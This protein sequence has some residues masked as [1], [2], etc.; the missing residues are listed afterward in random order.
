M[1]GPVLRA[2][3]LRKA[4]GGRA[5]VASVSFE[6]HGGEVVGLLGPN[7]AGKSTAFKMVAG[8]VRPDG[9]AVWLR[10]ARVDHL[11]LDARA[12][13]GLGYLPQE[14]TLFRDLDARDNVQIALD[15][16]GRPE[17]ADGLLARV[18]LEGMGR[19]AVT[20]LSGGERRRLQVARL[21]AIGPA[22]MLLDEPFAGID[23]IAIRGLQGLFRGLAAEGVGVLLTDHAVRETLG[24][25]DR[26]LI[27]DQGEVH[28]SGTPAEVVANPHARDRYL[29]HDFTLAGVTLQGVGQ[30]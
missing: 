3:G 1:T 13:L 5:V 23:P 15:A 16:S 25:C 19:R 7:G 21:L 30:S 14:D 26:A 17:P 28:A 27:L 20:G 10:G 22:V 8:L 24:T 2:E 11:P 12:R 18:G 29:G 4:Y 6:L 9:G